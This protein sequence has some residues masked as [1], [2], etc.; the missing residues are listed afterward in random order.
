[1]IA[2]CHDSQIDERDAYP[3]SIG[4]AGGSSVVRA[5][6]LLAGQ[7]SGD[8]QRPDPAEPSAKAM[9]RCSTR[10]GIAFGTFG[11]RRSRSAGSRGQGARPGP[12]PACRRQGGRGRLPY[13]SDCPHGREQSRASRTHDRPSRRCLVSRH[14]VGSWSVSAAD[15][16]A[17]A[18][19]GARSTPL[20]PER[21]RLVFLPRSTEG[22][23]N[24]G[25]RPGR[26]AKADYRL[27][28]HDESRIGRPH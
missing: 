19:L 13:R 22:M 25:D 20:N 27:R 11:W 3:P 5:A 1:M 24:R 15:N 7:L 12:T 16:S 2:L 6:V 23:K 28:P 10:S 4:R 21:A 17:A 8:A 14:G 9:M 26:A 18:R